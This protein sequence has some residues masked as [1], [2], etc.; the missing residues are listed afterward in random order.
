MATNAKISPLLKDKFNRLFK[1]ALV[2][3]NNTPVSERNTPVI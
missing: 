1:F 2:I 3:I